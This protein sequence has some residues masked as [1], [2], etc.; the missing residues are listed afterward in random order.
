M[1]KFGATGDLFGGFEVK[2]GF[3]KGG[4][5]AGFKHGGNIYNK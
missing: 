2:H 4:G 5:I 1:Y 3:A